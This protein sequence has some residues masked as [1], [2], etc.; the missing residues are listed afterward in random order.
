[1]VKQMYDLRYR[2]TRFC[3]EKFGV[4]IWNYIYGVKKKDLLNL[5]ERVIFV[6]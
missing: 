3:G 5:K 1:M 4:L 2:Y 6:I